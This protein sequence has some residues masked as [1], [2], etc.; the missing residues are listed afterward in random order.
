MNSSAPVADNRH[1]VSAAQWV[2]RGK[3]HLRWRASWATEL[4]ALE[5]Q[6]ECADD[7]QVL[8]KIIGRID[9]I[10][11]RIRQ[12]QRIMARHLERAP[13]LLPGLDSPSQVGGRWQ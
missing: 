5:G 9:V 10:Q 12:L 8:Q 11:K 3:C 7:I 2:D 6:V 1:E 13:D 4:N